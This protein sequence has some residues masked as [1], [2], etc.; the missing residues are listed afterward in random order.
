MIPEEVLDAR[1][2]V[3]RIKDIEWTEQRR[4]RIWRKQQLIVQIVPTNLSYV[5]NTLKVYILNNF[6]NKPFSYYIYNNSTVLLSWN[7]FSNTDD[8][9]S[10]VV[11]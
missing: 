9:P 1:A 11:K 10:Q 3:I 6:F 5:W 4:K 2:N 7:I 8:D